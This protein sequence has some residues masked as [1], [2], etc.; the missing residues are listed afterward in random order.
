MYP[1]DF[2]EF[3]WANGIGEDVI[4]HIQESF[5]HRESL[6]EGIHNK[7]LNL[8]RKYLLVG[9]LP[10]AVD[11]FVKETNI[12]RVRQIHADIHDLYLNDAAKYE[13]DSGR[14]LKIQRIYNMVPSTMENRK[15]RV[16]AKDIE[17]K[18]GKRMENYQDEFD[19]LSASG[20]AIECKAISKPSYP[21]P[22]NM[23]KNLL[24]LYMNDVGMLT[25]L[26]YRNNIKAVM[27]DIRSA[28][29]GSVYETFVAQELSAHGLGCFYYDNKKHGE[30]DFLIDDNENLTTIPIVVK[31]GRDYSIHSALN[32]FMTMEEYN[33]NQ[34]YVFSNER[35]VSTKDG[36]T[37]MPIYNVMF[38]QSSVADTSF[39]KYDQ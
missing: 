33:I 16:V 1:M 13:K 25:A 30:V 35:T 18:V 27:D 21:L 22:L 14:K 2:E 8:M 38:L 6:N 12:A 28:N 26:L 4:T 19:Y 11:S 3:L 10:A 24:K 15:K 34:S 32:H 5:L 7:M 17:D 37:Y 39:E 20:I 36:I 9:G 31:S 29:L 23:G